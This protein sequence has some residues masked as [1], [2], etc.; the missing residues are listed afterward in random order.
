MSALGGDT[1]GDELRRS[2]PLGRN[3][4]GDDLSGVVLEDGDLSGSDLT[5]ADFSG[6]D[7]SDCDLSDATLSGPT[8]PT[9]RCRM[10]PSRT[11]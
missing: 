10:R 2:R 1:R 3:F 6:T 4:V 11:R 9:P 8:S 7:L 5:D